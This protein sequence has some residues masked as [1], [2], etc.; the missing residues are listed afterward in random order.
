MRY[1]PLLFLF[2]ACTV[3]FGQD[4]RLD[5]LTMRVQK[6]EQTKA[7]AAAVQGALGQ[8]QNQIQAQPKK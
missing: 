3:H 4:A 6:L 1:L 2:S 8:L 7:D 5:D